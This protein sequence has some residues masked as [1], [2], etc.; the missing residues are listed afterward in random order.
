[1]TKILRNSWRV[2]LLCAA[3]ATSLTASADKLWS[4]SFDYQVG[5]LYG[6]GAWW[7]LAAAN[8]DEPVQVIDDALTFEGYQGTAAGKAVKLSATAL[9]SER[10]KREFSDTPMTEGTLYYAMLVKPTEFPQTNTTKFVIAGLAAKNFNGW[11]DGIG[12]TSIYNTVSISKGS[13]EGKFQFGFASA[14]SVPEPIDGDLDLGKTYLVVVGYDFATKDISFWLNPADADATPTKV[15]AGK[16]SFNASNG[17]QGVCLYQQGSSNAEGTIIV[18][19]VRVATDMASLFKEEKPQTKG[20][21]LLSDSFQYAKGDLYNQGAWWRLASANSADPIQVVDSALTYE[22]YQSKAMGMAAELA[23]STNNKAE[24]LKKEFS[25]TAVVAGELYYSLLVKPIEFSQDNTSKYI[26]AGLAGRNFNGWGDGIGNTSLF[27]TVSISKGSEEGKFQFGFAAAQ[28]VPTLITEDLDLGKTYLVVVGYD[29]ATKNLSFWLNPKD[30]AAEPTKVLE[31][32]GSV[33]V[34]N[35]VQGVALYQQGSALAQ[36]RIVVDHVRVATDMASLF[37]EESEEAPELKVTQTT[38]FTDV[39]APINEDTKFATFTVEAK[40]LEAAASIWLGGADRS[41]FALSMT[42]IP[43]GTGSYEVVVTY[44][45]TAIGRHSATVNFDA[46][47]TTLSGTYALAA[48]AYD[49]ANLPAITVPTTVDKFDADPN[50]TDEKTIT[51]SSA[52][53]F[54]YVYLALE[55]QSAPGTF[56]LDQGMLLGNGSYDVKISFKPTKTGDFTARLK[57]SSAMVDAQYIELTGHSEGTLP[58]GEKEGGELTLDTANPLTYLVENFDAVTHNKPLALTGWDNVAMTGTRAWWGYN[59]STGDH[60][61]AAKVTVY[62]SDAEYD[63][64]CE[65]LL[66]TPALDFKNAASKVFTCSVMGNFLPSAGTDE[67]LEVLY[68]ED[69]D[70]MEPL[71][72]LDIP[73]IS[74][75]NNEWRDYVIDFDGQPLA[76]VFFIGFRLK[77]YRGR[78][79]SMTYYVDNVSWGRTDIPQVKADTRLLTYEAGLDATVTSPTINV[80]GLNLTDDI[81]IKV[82]GPD[83]SFFTPSVPALP[84]EGGALTLESTFTEEREYAAYVELTSP[85]SGAF[86][87]EVYAN[88]SKTTGVTTVTAKTIGAKAAAYDLMGRKVTPA[89]SLSSGL[90][91]I[92]GRKVAK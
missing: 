62:D 10:V 25:D 7:R 13:E 41:Q 28:S 15:L 20:K 57:V 78:N 45:P 49:P 1:M 30:A 35:G 66:V 65:M 17:V 12:N 23:P 67:I 31:A 36:G 11:G 59:F 47:P 38:D 69:K 37:T 4:D 19:H 9:K 68:I 6:Q 86:L 2:M 16:G 82:S 74:D 56:Q 8:T 42:E 34:T 92:D 71:Q 29:F 72:G 33:H 91:I 76:D 70:F 24:R 54:D 79:A 60:G 46:V 90:Y 51:V 85:G 52:N 89:Q 88:A 63:T 40:N 50:E 27:N 53:M 64:P 87:I 14:Q 43:A 48:A 58:P 83:A 81:K 5:D 55:D 61:G 80:I 22:G 32:G 84:A 26:I 77:S 44:R 73:Y 21:L 75:E 39:A 18:D 3:L